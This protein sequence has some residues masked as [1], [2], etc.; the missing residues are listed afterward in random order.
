MATSSDAIGAERI[1]AKK[2]KA[3]FSSVKS[4]AVFAS[5]PHLFRAGEPYQFGESCANSGVYVDL[6]SGNAENFISRVEQ[7]GGFIVNAA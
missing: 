7:F 3:L 6:I 2:M 1:G 5:K 4:Y